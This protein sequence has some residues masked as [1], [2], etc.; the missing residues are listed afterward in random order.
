MWVFW[1]QTIQYLYPVS[2][3][4]WASLYILQYSFTEQ[5][6]AIITGW[7]SFSIKWLWNRLMLDWPK[8]YINQR[9]HT[10]ADHLFSYI[11]TTRQVLLCSNTSFMPP[12]TEVG[13]FHVNSG[14]QPILVGRNLG[15]AQNIPSTLLRVQKLQHDQHFNKYH[16]H[17]ELL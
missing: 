4:S 3:R 1:N 6:T 17:Q 15:W 7:S 5:N 12:F 11:W 10:I 14:F 13:D 9:P 2:T 8:H 16:E